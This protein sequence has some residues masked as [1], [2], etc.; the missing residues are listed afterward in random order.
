VIIAILNVCEHILQAVPG[1]FI[2]FTTYGKAKLVRL[3]GQKVK[4]QSQGDHGQ[5]KHYR[6]FEGY[7][8]ELRVTDNLPGEGSG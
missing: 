3:F 7:G 2:K 1:N 6:N 5:K 4:G 8:S